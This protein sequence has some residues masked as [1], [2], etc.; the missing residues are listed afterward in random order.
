MPL[1][2]ATW[3]D[4]PPSCELGA[5]PGKA[6]LHF[7]L[8]TPIFLLQQFFKFT[9]QKKSPQRETFVD[10]EEVKQKT[11]EAL[12]GIKITEFKHCFEQWKNIL[13]GVL[14]QMESIFMVTEV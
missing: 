1:N 5:G 10:V 11:A 13:I 9:G 2:S 6:L 3:A 14:H 8:M 7:Q 4:S 12:R